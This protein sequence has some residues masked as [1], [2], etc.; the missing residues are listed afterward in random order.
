MPATTPLQQEGTEAA[1]ADVCRQ[2]AREECAG[3]RACQ[4]KW[5]TQQGRR[6]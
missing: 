6:E 3:R 5:V 2:A 1:G 4:A